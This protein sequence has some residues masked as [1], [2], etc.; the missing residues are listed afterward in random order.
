MACF[1]IHVLFGRLPM[2]QNR[3]VDLK[4]RHSFFCARELVV[5]NNKRRK[6]KVGNES[7]Y[8]GDVGIV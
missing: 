4:T 1:V 6:R 7:S 2:P 5:K 3:R 8:S